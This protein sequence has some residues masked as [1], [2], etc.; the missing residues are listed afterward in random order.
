MRAE[1]LVRVGRLFGLDRI[2]FESQNLLD[3]ISRK[4][5]LEGTNI[6]K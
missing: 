3:Q 5:T 1:G 4:L 6:E 2:P